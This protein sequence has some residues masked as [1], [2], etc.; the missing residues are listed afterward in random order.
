M[1]L[2]EESVR[3]WRRPRDAVEWAREGPFPSVW[4]R[5]SD[6]NLSPGA[7]ML[8]LFLCGSMRLNGGDGPLGRHFL[9]PVSS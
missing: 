3:I 1:S 9:R 8:G 5:H 7:K 6:G 4:V 2:C